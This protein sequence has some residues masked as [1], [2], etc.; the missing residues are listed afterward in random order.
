MRARYHPHPHAESV[1][2]ESL[3]RALDERV[4][5]EVR[6]DAGSRGA[7]STDSS[8]FRQPP[9][10][11]VVPRDVDDVVATVTTC[12]EHGAP[13]THRGG[14]TSLAGQT[15]NVAVVVDWSKHLHRV[16][17]IDPATRTARVEPGC[18]LDHLRER[19]GEHDLTFGPDPATHNRC[20]LGGM[21]G[22]NS[23]GTHSIMAGRTADNVESLDVL[24]Y[25]GTRLTVGATPDDELERIVALGGRRGEIY[26]ALRD[27]R[28]RYADTIRA[29]YPDIPRRVSG[30]NLD[31]LLPERGFNVARALVGSEGTCVTVLGATLRLE[32]ARAKRALVVLGYPDAGAAGD[33]VPM[34]LEHRPIGLEG[35]D[36]RLV[37]FLRRKGLRTDDIPLLPDG[38][39]FLLV[40]FGAETQDDADAQAKTFMDE[41]GRVERAPDVA[42][43]DDPAQEQKVWEV[44][45]SGL[46]ATALVPGHPRTWPGWEDA[47]VPPEQIGEYLRAFRSL[48][49]R[50]D[51][52]V[53]LYG[54]FGQG[55]VHTRIDF[56]LVTKA[57]VD[58]YHAF[59]EDA[60]D[61]VVSMGGSLSGEHGDGQ[62]RGPLLEKM[63]GPD[64]VDAFRRFQA[65]WD[66][67]D[68]MNPGKVVDPVR[69]FRTTE[70]LRLGTSYA[71]WT[72]VT[73][74][75]F[76]D[77]SGSFEQ[78]ANRC[79]G[80]GK[81]RRTGGGTMCPSYMVTREEEHSTRG[82]SRLL[83]EMLDGEVVADRWRSK[84]VHDALDLC[85]ACKGCKSDCPVNVDMAT[86]KAEFL[87]HYYKGRIRPRPAYAMGLIMYHARLASRMPDVA[88]FATRAPGVSSLLKRAAG[89][90]TKR[91]APRF[92]DETFRDW[93]ARRPRH[94]AGMPPVVLFPDT[95]TNFLEPDVG[96]ATTEV[97]EAAGFEVTI[98]S[99]VL[100]CARPLFD[101]GMLRTAKHLFRQVLRTLR[102][103]IEAGLPIVVP[104]PSCCA[105]FRDELIG[106]FPHDR[107]AQRLAQQAVT[108]DE[109]LD[110]HAPRW[111]P[112][113]VERPV[114]VQ[115]HCHQGA[116]LDAGAR[117]RVLEHA[118]AAVTAPDTGCCGLAGSFGFEASKYDV[119]MACGERA[120]FPAVRDASADTVVLADGFSCRTQIADGTGRR[121][122]HLAQLL[123]AGLPSVGPTGSRVP[124]NR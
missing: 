89:L 39:A 78:A 103:E 27:L 92:A 93:F 11:V 60:S 106:L 58:A 43:F 84:A 83:F 102:P 24:L 117:R 70:N 46:G 100:C 59:L 88:N 109:L 26:A 73:F 67:D 30:Y 119:S 25:D 107:D 52:D 61:L 21:I 66:P 77:D 116:V 7:Y 114:L 99:R 31:E 72:P 108:L 55:C 118:D 45:E 80:V 38:D 10:G 54:H 33:H 65:V 53:A 19:A 23:C 91:P 57:G 104:E 20:T 112:P 71:P 48:C 115:T 122:V 69:A 5:G 14:G 101:Y 121:A 51:Y 2:V 49:A 90:T 34:I 82:R 74:F 4:R 85:L 50:H 124:Q 41:I 44:R 37:Q 81:C 40:E 8:N 76:P 64:L 120:L 6:F 94:N 113:R 29:R 68:R 3:R 110:R 98:P 16:V 87:A 47:A 35:F 32:P 95:F 63:F 12:R 42:F 56:D 15:T 123:R 1:D 111:E 96:C 75:A 86:Y 22:N 97:A 9:I 28:D 62:Q 36:D 105:S 79:V 13:I 18:V 17:E